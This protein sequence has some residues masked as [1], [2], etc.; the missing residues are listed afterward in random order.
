MS[1]AHTDAPAYLQI[2]EAVVEEDVPSVEEELLLADAEQARHQRVEGLRG[3]KT[4]VI[5]ASD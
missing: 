4:G 2:G 1:I 5:T 3:E